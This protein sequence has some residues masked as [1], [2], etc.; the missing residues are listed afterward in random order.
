MVDGELS[1]NYFF[2]NFCYFRQVPGTFPMSFLNGNCDV[3]FL[4]HVSRTTILHLL[5]PKLN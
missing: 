2:Y 1:P 3:V 4:V 5:S